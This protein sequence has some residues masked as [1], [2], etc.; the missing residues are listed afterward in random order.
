MPPGVA[1]WVH[2]T[3]GAGHGQKKDLCCLHV[4]MTLVLCRGSNSVL[5]AELARAADGCA[6]ER[7]EESLAIP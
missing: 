1:S 2:A 4:R 3:A 5:P 6:V 7:V